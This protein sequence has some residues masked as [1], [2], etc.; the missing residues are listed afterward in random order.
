MDGASLAIIS[1]II[2]L[3]FF[4]PIWRLLPKF[5]ISKFWTLICF[6]PA[7]GPY[8]MIILLYVMAFRDPVQNK[9]DGA[10]T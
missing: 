5:G 4:Y 1:L 9:F 7:V 6:L 10:T 8:G 3:L 2:G